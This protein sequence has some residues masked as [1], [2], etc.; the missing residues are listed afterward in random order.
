M[1]QQLRPAHTSA[2]LAAALLWL[3]LLLSA[4]APQSESA[5]PARG[6][7][8]ENARDAEVTPLRA[9]SALRLDIRSDTGIGGADVQLDAGL[10]VRDI[11]LR[12][13]VRG[14]EQLTFGAPDGTVSPS[15]FLR[16]PR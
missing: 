13:H 14:L 10:E 5:T 8:I 12:L 3:G 2:S 9:G 16:Q 6:V 1:T 15:A 11:V 7:Q 4:C